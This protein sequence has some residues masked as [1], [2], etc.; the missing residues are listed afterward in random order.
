MYI[1]LQ[2]SKCGDCSRGPFAMLYEV[3]QKGYETMDEEYKPKATAVTDIRCHCGHNERYDGPMF[4]YV[5]QIVFD[6]FIKGEEV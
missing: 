3:W 6:E 2:C 1:D 5:F 4:T